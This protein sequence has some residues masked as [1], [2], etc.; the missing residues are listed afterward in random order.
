LSIANFTRIGQPIRVPVSPTSATNQFAV[1]F[2]QEQQNT[3]N[4]S[5]FFMNPNSF[6]VRL[7]GTG[8]DSLGAPATF[9]QVGANGI[10]GWAVLA[11]ERTQV[12]VSKRPLLLSAY[13]WDNPGNPLVS[14][15]DYTNC[16][17]ELTYGRVS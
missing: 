4:L 1:N 7:E 15:Y 8:L 14:G 3:P 9:M 6:D 13:A 12:W 11:R 2:T 5:F 10:L 16:F 17:L